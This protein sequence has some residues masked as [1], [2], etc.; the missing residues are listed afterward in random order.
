[1]QQ[2]KTRALNWT[3]LGLG[4]AIAALGTTLALTMSSTGL[5]PGPWFDRGGEGFARGGAFAFGRGFGGMWMGMHMMGGVILF[6]VIVFAALALLRRQG[7]RQGTFAGH[8]HEEDATTLLR[9]EFAEGRI[10]EDQYK[11]R[12]AALKR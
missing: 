4:I 10:S 7:F 9:V 6:A 8:A 2:K 3:L 12:L 11:E 5:F 1:M